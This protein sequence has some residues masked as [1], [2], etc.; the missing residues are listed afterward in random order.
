MKVL[1]RAGVV[2]GS[3]IDVLMAVGDEQTDE[4]VSV[5]M[6]TCIAASMCTCIAT[7]CLSWKRS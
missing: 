2:A 1:T 6:C 5:S 3:G 4:H 7:P